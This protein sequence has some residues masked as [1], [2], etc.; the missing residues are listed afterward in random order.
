MPVDNSKVALAGA[1]FHTEQFLP[2]GGRLQSGPFR[3]AVRLIYHHLVREPL[4]QPRR[5]PDRPS[6]LGM[7][8]L[9]RAAVALIA[10][11]T[12]AK[13]GTVIYSSVTDLG[14]YSW[15]NAYRSDCGPRLSHHPPPAGVIDP[16][17]ELA[18]APIDTAR[19]IKFAHSVVLV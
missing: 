11:V 10:L 9:V 15:N 6:G 18:T 7:R 3:F 5:E 2:A 19:A 13:A 1:G 12:Q 4:T 14:G 17:N 16:P 8:Y